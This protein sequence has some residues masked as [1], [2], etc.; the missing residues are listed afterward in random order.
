MNDMDEVRERIANA[1]RVAVL[2]GAGVSAESGV[3][4][5]RGAGGLWRNF[6][7]MKLATLEGFLEDPKTVWEWYDYRRGQ[8]AECKPNPAHHAIAKLEQNTP[9]FL[10]ITQNI[11]GLHRLAG[12]RQIAEMHGNIWKV[13]PV[14][15]ERNVT[16]N[17]DVPLKNIPLT[18]EKGEL[19]RPAVVWFG[20][21]LPARELARAE[22]FMSEPPDVLVVVGTSSQISWVQYM[23]M[24]ARAGRSQIVEVNTEETD[25]S[26]MAHVTLIGKAGEVLP[27]LVAD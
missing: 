23:V 10:L 11:D 20:E 12:S 19:L 22:K 26:H 4:T 8:M 16:E 24:R 7:Y 13:R 1:Q 25:L 18:D 21:M 3:P 2:T 15:D 9:E 5:F 27:K 6:D 17:R 14:D